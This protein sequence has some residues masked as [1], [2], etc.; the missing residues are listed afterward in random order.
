MEFCHSC[1]LPG[2]AQSPGPLWLSLGKKHKHQQKHTIKIVTGLGVPE[3]LN[4][5][6]WVTMAKLVAFEGP[7][8]RCCIHAVQLVSAVGFMS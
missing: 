2:P 8:V 4:S 7:G 3:C 1:P 5:K 6:D